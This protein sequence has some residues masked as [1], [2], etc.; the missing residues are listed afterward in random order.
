VELKLNEEI[1]A[2]RIRAG[3]TQK[4]LGEIVGVSTG[5]IYNWEIGK[6][7]PDVIKMEKIRNVSECVDI[8]IERMMGDDGHI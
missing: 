3:I 6:T 2:L 8:L 5:T 1:R 4:Q 7:I